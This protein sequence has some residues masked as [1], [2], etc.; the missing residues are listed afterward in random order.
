MATGVQRAERD[1]STI[2]KNEVLANDPKTFRITWMDDKDIYNIEYSCETERE[3]AEIVAKIKF[4]LSR[5]RN[6]R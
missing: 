1:I 3:C 2:V 6:K 4:I 5:L